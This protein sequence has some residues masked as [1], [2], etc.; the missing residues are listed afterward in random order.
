MGIKDHQRTTRHD[1]RDF[2][3]IKN[4]L[5]GPQFDAIELYPAEDRL[6]DTSNQYYMFVFLGVRVPF[7]WNERLVSEGSIGKSRQRPWDP[8]VRPADLTTANMIQLH[9]H[10]LI[11]E[12]RAHGTVG[13]AETGGSEPGTPD[14]KK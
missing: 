5:I 11:Q 10:R 3:R 14:D 8:D 13:V 9:I 1:W 2:Q 7:G 6:V 4:E 12:R